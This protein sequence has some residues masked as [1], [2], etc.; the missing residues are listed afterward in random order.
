MAPQVQM[1]IQTPGMPGAVSP[2]TGA[3]GSMPNAAYGAPSTLPQPGPIATHQPSPMLAQPGTIASPTPTPTPTPTATLVGTAGSEAVVARVKD[4]QADPISSFAAPAQLIRAR[5]K[6]STEML[7]ML[8]IMGLIAVGI[9]IY[10]IYYVVNRDS[11][12]QSRRDTSKG[13]DGKET[14]RPKRDDSNKPKTQRSA[15]ASKGQ[16]WVDASTSPQHTGNV[17]VSIIRAFAGPLPGVPGAQD[18]LFIQIRVRNVV[19]SEPL[20]IAR[21]EHW[22]GRK[23]RRSAIASDRFGN[24]LMPKNPFG[25]TLTTGL[26]RLQPNGHVD[27]FLIFERPAAD[28][29]SVRLKLDASAVGPRGYL[30]FELPAA[31]IETADD[32]H[33]AWLYATLPPEAHPGATTLPDLPAVT[34]P[35]TAVPGAVVP[36]SVDAIEAAIGAPPAVPE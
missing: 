15:P 21:W 35:D 24:L 19:T 23:F 20:E 13:V 29:D 17:R 11:D 18:Y 33:L 16:D 7:I 31:M 5:K 26:A 12:S 1:P 9:G 22:A 27:Q 6:M 28:V 30:R 36:G 14:K 8:S 32:A 3:P 34:Q 25:R 2:T 10:A 4:D